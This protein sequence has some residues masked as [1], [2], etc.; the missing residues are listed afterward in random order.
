[1]KSKPAHQIRLG[2]IKAAVWKNNTEAGVRYNVTFNRLYK[3]GDQWASTE[4][5]GRDDL[6]LLA[7]VADHTHSWICSQPQEEPSV[8]EPPTAANVAHA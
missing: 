4:S 6:L 1:M 7:K 2:A 3:Q 8:P 5:F